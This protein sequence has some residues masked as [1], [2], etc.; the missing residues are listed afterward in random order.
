MSVYLA[1]QPDPE[2]VEAVLNRQ[3]VYLVHLLELQFASGTVYLSNEI[4]PFTDTEWGH[5][6][7]GMGN[8]VSMSA[9]QA[10]RR[11]LA[12]VME[13]TLGIPWEFL[14]EGER[15][16]NGMGLIP[17][18]IGDPAEYRNRTATL[19]EQVFDDETLD[20][21]GRPTPVGIPS[22]IHT[23]RMDTVR[24]TYA[25]ASANVTLSVEGPL[26]RKGAPV[27]GRLTPRDQYKRYPGDHGLDYVTEVLNTTVQWTTF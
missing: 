1:N 27:F 21:H 15:G 11:N 24:A 8:L 9:V 4:V 3:S 2:E 10:G 7:R 26:S 23:G 17:G 12:P 20:S 22:A 18:L 6:W 16:V 19:W 14:T 25:L 5:T 13:Y